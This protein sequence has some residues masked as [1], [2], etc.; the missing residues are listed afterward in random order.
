VGQIQQVVRHL[1]VNALEA[2]P[3]GGTIRIRGENVNL[4]SDEMPSLKKGSYVRIA[5]K[6]QG[7]GIP[8]EY[9]AKVFD[10][11]F[12]TKPL[13]NVKGA[14]LGLAICYSII[15]KHEG[16][17]SLSSKPGEGTTFTLYLPASAEVPVSVHS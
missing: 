17:L 10:P 16:Y 9:Q 4:E 6:D 12:T 8:R 11:Y 5:F 3:D 7:V 15:K 2:M 1:V 13:G 14:G